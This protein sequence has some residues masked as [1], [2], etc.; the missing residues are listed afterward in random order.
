VTAVAVE[1]AA[2]IRG[3]VAVPGD[4]S[5]SHRALLISAIAEGES[6]IR[7]LGVSEDV[8]ATASAV[9]ALGVDVE[10]EGDE[11]R[12][13][14]VGLRGLR[15]PE[16]PI[17]CG[18]AGTLMRLLAGILAGQVGRFE[19]VGDESLSRRPLERITEPLQQMGARVKATD[20][21][22][23]LVVEG[24][25]LRAI[26]YELPVASAQVKSAVLLGGLYAEDGPTVVFEPAPTRD[27]TERMLEEAGARM[28]RKPG[29]PGV[30][31][32][33]RLRPLALDVP[34]DASSAAPFLVAASALSG[35][36]L[37]VHGVGVNPTRTGF[38]AVLERMGARISL[39]NRRSEGGEP[40]ADLEVAS[41]ELVGTTVRPEEVP[42]LV[43]ELPLFALIAGMARGKSVV[44]G[45]QELRV[46]ESDRIESV[47]NVL[48]PLGI[49]IET[50]HDGF[51]VRGVP[52]R[53][54]GGGTVDAGGDH[55][56]A[57]LAGIAGLVSREGVRIEGAECVGVSF[58]DFFAMLESIAVR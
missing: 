52:S 27:H 34:G 54:K 7:S 23:P 37:R 43:D 50:A 29:A 46:K 6:S 17:D 11:A 5:I 35:S 51:R 55:R 19:L 26:R 2:S 31:P 45:A 39:F 41:A 32:A 1:P 10:I 38:L 24:S 12:V 13:G 48:R 40:V 3:D 18:N 53:P 56:I 21:H 22:A 30:W 33:E 44:R 8:L 16:R 47:K 42:Q 36:E 57:M 4:K 58:P 28:R 15:A 20:G 25:R 9:Q 49:H 14:G